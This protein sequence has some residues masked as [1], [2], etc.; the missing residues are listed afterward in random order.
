MKSHHKTIIHFFA[1]GSL[2]TLSSFT[3]TMESNG[4]KI[5]KKSSL[6]RLSISRTD[7]SQ[8]L[9]GGVGLINKLNKRLSDGKQCASMRR[10]NLEKQFNFLSPE[11]KRNAKLYSPRHSPRLIRNNSP[12]EMLGPIKEIVKKDN[13]DSEVKILQI[14]AQLKTFLNQNPH[15]LANSPQSS[16][17]NSNAVQ[18]KILTIEAK[19]KIE[20]ERRAIELGFS[21]ELIKSF[22]PRGNNLRIT[23][24]LSN[25]K[26]PRDQERIIIER[27]SKIVSQKGDFTQLLKE[28]KEILKEISSPNNSSLLKIKSDNF[29][30]NSQ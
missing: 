3:H 4:K 13:T 28:V 27:I 23:T 15:R 30:K 21:P 2:I 25:N 8:D 18:K 26:S 6:K 17:N 19:L 20:Q 11:A 1:Y 5:K 24:Q 9:T 29:F 7:S 10:L 16:R 12:R 14:R 22:K